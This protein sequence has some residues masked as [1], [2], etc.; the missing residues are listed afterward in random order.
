MRRDAYR[1]AAVISV[2]FVMMMLFLPLLATPHIPLPLTSGVV[3][4]KSMTPVINEG[5]LIIVDRMTGFSDTQRGDIV[6]F[7]GHML[8]P[9]SHRVIEHDDTT[10]TTK[11]DANG[12]ADRPIT[13]DQY[14]GRVMLIVPTHMLGPAGFVIGSLLT[15]SGILGMCTC[16]C[17]VHYNRKKHAKN[18]GA[19][20]SA[21]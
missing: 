20:S 4:T 21:F 13:K 10:I 16:A 18:Q 17:C 7:H 9:I 2:L 3:P 8:Q 11:G 14:L 19:K 1:R 12:F 15:V 5:D 6:M